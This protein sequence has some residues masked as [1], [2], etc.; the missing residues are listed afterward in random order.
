MVNS[1]TTM[2]RRGTNIVTCQKFLLLLWNLKLQEK[3][4]WVQDWVNRGSAKEVLDEQRLD[5]QKR[6]EME[7]REIESKVDE[8]GTGEWLIEQIRKD[9]YSKTTMSKIEYEHEKSRLE[10]EMQEAQQELN[11]H[12]GRIYFKMVDYKGYMKF[13]QE[14]CERRNQAEYNYVVHV[15]FKALA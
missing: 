13:L 1:E 9:S 10:G 12:L 14:L 5:G 2:G 15:T 11:L 6:R 8:I 3:Q 7:D 4:E